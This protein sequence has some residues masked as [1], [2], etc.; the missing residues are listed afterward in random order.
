MRGPESLKEAWGVALGSRVQ[1]L[2]FRVGIQTSL[3]C[4]GVQVYAVMP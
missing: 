3:S 4:S 1:G 2:G